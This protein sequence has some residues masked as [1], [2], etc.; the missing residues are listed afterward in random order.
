MFADNIPI[1]KRENSLL[2]LLLMLGTLWLATT[3]YNF[4]QTPY[5][6]ESNNLTTFSLYQ[7]TVQSFNIF[8][9]EINKQLK[10]LYIEFNWKWDFWC[11]TLLRP[12]KESW[13]QTTP[14][15]WPSSP[16]A[17]LGVLSSIKYHFSNLMLLRSGTE[18]SHFNILKSS[19]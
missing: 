6:Q 2:F 10:L 14:S 19:Y 4:N 3:L 1:C 7:V 5:L 8:P 16:S 15:Q 18:T 9:C 12:I 11:W 17:S 13:W